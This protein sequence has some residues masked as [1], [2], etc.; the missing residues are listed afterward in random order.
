MEVD[1]DGLDVDFYELEVDFHGSEVDFYELEVDPDGLEV[2]PDG[3]EVDPDGLEV[4]P[5]GLEVDPDGLEVDPDRLEV[6]PDGSE[7]D[8]DG[9]KVD[10][11]ACILHVPMSRGASAPRNVIFVPVGREG[12]VGSNGVLPTGL[13]LHL[14]CGAVQPEG[15]VNIDCSHR[16]RL[17][18]TLPR[19]DRL[20]CRLGVLPPTEFGPQIKIHNLLRPFPYPPQ[21]ISCIYAGEVWEHFEYPDC[22]RLTA[23]CYRV[24]APGGVLRLCVPDGPTFWRRYLNVYDEMAARPRAERSPEPLRELVALYYRE[25]C[26]RRPGFGSMGHKHKWQFDEVQMVDL[27]ESQGFSEVERKPFHDSRIGDVAAVEVANQLIVEG[28]KPKIPQV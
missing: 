19:V 18:A 5:D 13:K 6:D 25:I 15:W 28:V 20:L 3:L 9:L 10:P 2:D 21:S 4:D 12:R 1:F 11:K 26:T 14:G 8:P 27:F 23:E 24:L 17:A 16:A 7:V 22:V